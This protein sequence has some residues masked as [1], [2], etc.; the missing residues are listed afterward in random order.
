MKNINIPGLGNL[1]FD[2]L[3]LDYN[4]TVAID[5]KLIEGVDKRLQKLSEE[6]EIYVLTADTFGTAE[7]ECE[8]L[9]VNLNT[10]NTDDT[11]TYKRKF[12]DSLGEKN[13]ICIGNGYNDI[14]MLKAAGISI[15]TIQSEGCSGKAVVYSDVVVNSILDALDIIIDSDKLKATLRG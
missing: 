6:L 14:E 8:G 10:F 7:T 1:K 9:D 4:G 11:S 15:C 13:S 3:V 2:N 12:V 5:G